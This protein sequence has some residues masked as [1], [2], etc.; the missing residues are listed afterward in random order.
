M[1]NLQLTKNI[2]KT[3]L[4]NNKIINTVI[5]I[6]LDS[7]DNNSSECDDNMQKTKGIVDISHDDS[8]DNFDVDNSLN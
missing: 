2:S 3:D 6:S 8:D 4:L 7:S 1:N 5:D